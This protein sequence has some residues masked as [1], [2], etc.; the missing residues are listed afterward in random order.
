MPQSLVL[1]PVLFF[2]YIN[3]ITENVQRAKMNLF[4]DDTNLLITGE[5][6][7][8]LQQKIRNVVKELEM[9]FQ[10]IF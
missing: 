9:W 6:E 5:D 1:G 3:D 4:A 2:L 10:K 8:D 7:L